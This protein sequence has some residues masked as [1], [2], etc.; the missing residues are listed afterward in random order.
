MESN[1]A[2]DL[3]VEAG[4]NFYVEQTLGFNSVN[5]KHNSMNDATSIPRALE[6][7][8]TAPVSLH[9]DLLVEGHEAILTMSKAEKK[10]I[11]KHDMKLDKLSDL[12]K[13]KIIVNLVKIQNDGTVEVDVAQSEPVAS[14]LLELDAIDVTQNDHNN[15]IKE[16]S[17]AIPRLKIAILVVG[18]RGDVQPFLAIAKRLQEFGHYVRLATHASFRTFVKSAGIDFYPLGGDARVL[19]GYMARN[20]GLFPSAPREITIQRTQMKAIIDST[21]SAC[22]EPD[23]DSGLPFKAQA[24]IANPPSY[25]HTHVAE[26]LGVPLHIFFTMPWTPTHEFPHPLARVAQSA[27]YRLSYVIVDLM[28]WWGIRTFINDFRRTKLKLAPIAYFSTYNNSISHLPTGYM[29]SPHLVP[30]PS[31]W[32]ALVD[33]VGFCF[34]N[35]GTKYLPS[36]QFSEWIRGGQMPIYIGFGSMPLEDAKKTTLTILEA[37]KDTGQRGI[38]DR[39]WGDLGLFIEVPDNVFLLED[40]PHDW[41]FPQ[42]AA[43]CPTT[44][45]PF[46][47]DQFFWGDRIHQIG[48]GPKPIPIYE[49]NVENLSNAIRFMLQ[50]EVKEQANQLAKKIENEDGVAAA[51]DAFH[52]HLPQEL[53]E[54]TVSIEEEDSPHPFQWL[55]QMIEKTCCLPCT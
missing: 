55:F 49:L 41:L 26:A 12:E 52:R 53:P 16:F 35:L 7:C 10:E 43:V 4:D 44:I 21:L 27:G 23:L 50:P 48:L 19:A 51:V 14:E 33:V 13:K 39:G 46:F 3:Q 2:V 17:R 40:C 36:V 34:L 28:I 25:G 9:K 8:S 37:L 45:V 38:I 29:W 42:C 18:T 54:P 11:S 15:S 30:K 32:D 31:D 1:G 22:T 5:G 24:I 20:K 6:H 47:G